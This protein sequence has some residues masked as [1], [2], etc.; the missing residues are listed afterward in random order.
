MVATNEL[1][2]DVLLNGKKAQMG[3]KQFSKEL[4]KIQKSAI[5]TNKSLKSAFSGFGGISSLIGGGAFIKIA[6]DSSVAAKS[7]ENLSSRTGVLPSRLMAIGKAFEKSGG[8]AENVEQTLRKISDDI[9]DLQISGKVSPLIRTLGLMGINTINEKGEYISPDEALIKLSDWA[10]KS[11][12]DIGLQKTIK[13]LSDNFGLSD[14]NIKVL[15]QGSDN[16]SQL[17]EQQV[18]LTDEQNKGLADLND[19]GRSFVAEFKTFRDKFVSDIPFLTDSMNFLSDAMRELGKDENRIGRDIAGVG[20]FLLGSQGL[21]F[22]LTNGIKESASFVISKI[23]YIAAL[24]AG[25]MAGDWFSKK[26]FERIPPTMSDETYKNAIIKLYEEGKITSE[27][28]NKQ[29]ER[30]GFGIFQG[31]R[32]RVYQTDEFGRVL[33]EYDEGAMETELQMDLEYLKDIQNGAES[34]TIYETKDVNVSMSIENN[35]TINANGNVSAGEIQ[36]GISNANQDFAENLYS[37]MSWRVA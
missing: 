20:A 18:T 23:P 17:I 28:A 1:V 36:Q 31:S 12:S 35:N 34:S 33:G 6:H 13:L 29:F 37:V 30:A 27:E 15:I 4:S 16:L 14:E 19:A 24:V 25:G 9:N 22:L 3:L 11:A 32:K 2:I 7:I 26:I 10:K 21:K 5:K 8:K